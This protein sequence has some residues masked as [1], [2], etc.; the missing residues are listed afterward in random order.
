LCPHGGAQLSSGRLAHQ[1][2]SDGPG[3]YRVCRVDALLRCPW[4]GGE[5][6][7]RTGQSWSDPKSART[8]SLKTEQVNGS[9]LVKGPYVAAT[10]PVSMSPGDAASALE[11]GTLDCVLGSVSWLHSYGYMD[12]VQSVVDS[13][14][15]NVGP[16][17]LMFINRDVWQGMS[18]ETHATHVRLAPE[19]IVSATL[20]GQVLNDAGI[21]ESALEAG[22]VFTPDSPKFQ[23]IMIEQDSRQLQRVIDEAIAAR[24]EHLAEILDF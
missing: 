6:D 24:V 23:V 12:V 9:E 10:V 22:I 19:L 8:R 7:L 18:P 15:A 3:D 17:L 21:V 1:V 4:H 13:P 5:Y 20:E 11:R 2:E 16:P 14:I